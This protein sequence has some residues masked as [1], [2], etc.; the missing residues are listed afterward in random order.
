MS[1]ADL[2]ALAAAAPLALAGR[3]ATAALAAAVGARQFTDDPLTAATLLARGE[4]PV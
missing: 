3:G 2:A 1:E 4:L